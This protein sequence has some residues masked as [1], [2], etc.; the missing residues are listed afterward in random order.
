MIDLEKDVIQ[1]NITIYIQG[2]KLVQFVKERM[3]YEFG[4]NVPLSINYGDPDDLGMFQFQALDDNMSQ[5]N[6]EELSESGFVVEDKESF[7][8]MV[9]Q[10]YFKTMETQV[11]DYYESENYV[12]T[13][14][15]ITFNSKEYKEFETYLQEINEKDMFSTIV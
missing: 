8:Y 15:P 4:I 14:F 11:I 5:C 3:I 7:H 9:M 10:E 12:D 2:D 1:K 13:V 6:I